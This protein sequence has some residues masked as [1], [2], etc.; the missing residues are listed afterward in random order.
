MTKKLIALVEVLMVVSLFCT[1]FASWSILVPQADPNTAMG[2]AIAYDVESR[3]YKPSD[4]GIDLNGT[5]SQSATGEYVYNSTTKKYELWTSE[6]SGTRYTK[7]LTGNGL[8]HTTET[9]GG[10][11]SYVFTN[12]TLSV[13]L[14]VDHT[15]MQACL[16][17]GDYLDFDILLTLSAKNTNNQVYSIYGSAQSWESLKLKAPETAKISVK[18]YPNLYVFAE[19][20]ADAN[21]ML[22]LRIPIDRIYNLAKLD[23]LAKPSVLTVEMEFDATDCVSNFVKQI[24]DHHTFFTIQ[25]ADKQAR[26]A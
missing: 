25:T 15:Q 1:G 14:L 19:P 18:G 26:A 6:S 21:G 20:A 3:L 24:S 9:V 16:S 23:K 11:T 22:T 12:T 2:G 4:F 5:Y 13:E 7:T 8:R 17:A 10:T